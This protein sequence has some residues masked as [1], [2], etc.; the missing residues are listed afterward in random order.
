MIS[1][2]SKVWH[3]LW[4]Q[5]ARTFQVILVIALGA[6][7]I[8]LVVGGR[9]LIAGTIADQWRQANPPH[10]KLSVTPALTADQL[11]SL[12]RMEGVAQVEGLMSSS[13][14]WRLLGDE[15]W[16]TARLEAR[17]DFT[18]Q[19]METIGLISGNWPTRNTLG[20]IKTADTLYGVGEGATIEVRSNDQV[21]AYDLTG[22]LKPVG[23]F[24][25]V[26]L[27]SPVFYAD[28]ATFTRLTG[29]EAYDLVLTQDASFDLQR[30]EATDLEIQAYFEDINVDSVGTGFPNLTRVLSPDI[31][32]ADDL[33]NAL[34]L[35]LGVIGF[36]IIIL[37]IFL[38]YNSVNAIINQQVN[39][40]GVMKAVGARPWQVVYSYFLLVFTYGLLAVAVAIPLGGL[41]ARG[42]QA[43]F[44]N[45]LNLVDPGFSF[46]YAAIAVQIAVCLAV[47]LIAAFLPLRSS[48]RITV[49]EAISTYGLNGAAGFLDQALAR[50]VRLP[51]TLLLVISNTFRNRKRVLL[52]EIT[53]VIAGTIFMMVIGVNDATIFTFGDKLTSIHTYQVSLAFEDLQRARL[54]ENLAQNNP[55]VTEIESWLVSGGTARTISQAES[56]VTDSRVSLF[57]MPEPSSMY[58]PELLEGRWLLP[59]DTYAAVIHQRL[60]SVN[61]WKPGDWITVTGANGNEEMWQVVGVV[62]DPIAR[63]ALFVPL[64]TLQRKSGSVGQVNTLWVRTTNQDS[65]ALAATALA[66]TNAYNQ[67]GIQVSPSSTFGNNTIAR[68]VEETT[69]GF[70]LI[71]QLLAIM[72]IIIAVVGGVGL[73][74]V[75]TLNVLERRR[76][77]GVMRSIGASTWR[78]IRLYVGEGVLLGWLSWL[79]A[80]PLSIPAAYGLATFGLSVALN[81]QLAYR[82]SLTGALI[83]LAIITILAILASAFPARG[84]S[85][86][87]V[88]ESLAYQ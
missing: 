22:T 41:G 68:I 85:R 36:V 15:E 4:S 65:D 50:L 51:Y 20:V 35:I 47:P 63:N 88:R 74:G 72:A 29:S 57:G 38:V 10:I 8:G 59:G 83:W 71:I 75:L 3:D 53:L 30:A 81:Q 40:I 28:R 25:V 18:Q 33:L 32:P 49:R 34:F 17:Q 21:R 60:A 52:I 54:V 84:A 61:G 5:K 62:F 58:A 7:G 48:M 44:I 23:P 80:L 43:L 55:D 78:V 66:L 69:G 9:N 24:P 77:I 86:I 37:G 76:E 26:F 79:I 12:E 11:R 1:L 82:F 16:Q 42:L 87:S 27:G 2:L 13:I 39:Q 6:M 64:T 73:S 56:A 31:P 70:S 45:L 67:R 46:D 14:E 19:K